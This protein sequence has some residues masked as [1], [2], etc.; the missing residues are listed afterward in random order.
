MNCQFK[1]GKYIF[2]KNG[3]YFSATKEQVGELSDICNQ[4]LEEESN[5]DRTKQS[6]RG[7]HLLSKSG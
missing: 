7:E 4:I 5:S 6:T 2:E 3:V 1:N